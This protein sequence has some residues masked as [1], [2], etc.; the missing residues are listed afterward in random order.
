MQLS[1]SKRKTFLS[2]QP[3]AIGPEEIAAVTETLESGWLTS[4]PRAEELERRLA[5]LPPRHGGR[6]LLPRPVLRLRARS[7]Q[8]ATRG[9]AQRP[10]AARGLTRMA[11]GGQPKRSRTA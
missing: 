5:E 9:R 7:G 3:P 11:A 6:G 4:G 2:F 1:S 8:A 10:P